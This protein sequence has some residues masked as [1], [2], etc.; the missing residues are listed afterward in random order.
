MMWRKKKQS[1]TESKSPAPASLSVTIVPPALAIVRSLQWA[2][3]SVIVI[4]LGLAGYWWGKSVAFDDEITRLEMATARAESLTARLRTKMTKEGLTLSAEQTA[5][6]RMDVAFLNQ[7]A[8]KRAFSWVRLL[9]D[10][11]ETLPIAVSIASI[12]VNFQESTVSLNGTAH[13]LQSLNGFVTALQNHQAFQKASLVNHHLHEDEAQ[14][15]R[16][17][18]AA[19]APEIEFSLAAQYR[20]HTEGTD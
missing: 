6:V 10:L 2:M 17:A 14:H 7:L 1:P 12:K 5:R 16:T 4:A 11:E 18:R 19:S 9:S 8:D 15:G 20:L 13:D 3:V